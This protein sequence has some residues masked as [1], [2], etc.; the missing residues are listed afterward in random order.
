MHIS[1]L[2]GTAI[3]LQTK[4]LENDV[5]VLIDPYK[6]TTG[7][8][9]RSLTADVALFTRGSDNSLTLSGNPFILDTPGEIDSKGVLVTG[10]P[11]HT[12]DSI[13]FRVDIEGVSMAHLGLIKESLTSAQLEVLSHIDIVFIPVGNTRAFDTE[14]ATK[15]INSLEP[16]IIIPIAFKSDNDP[17]AV[18]PDAFI[19]SLGHQ[20][21]SEEKKVIIK[22][23]DLPEEETRVIL[24]GKE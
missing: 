8:A 5:V 23:K 24:L 22:K 12:E 4:H 13:M 20:V 1:W 16:R 11:G 9:P 2:G 10:I 6:P 18:S 14:A 17:D 19:R 3:R 21:P 15:A 7:S